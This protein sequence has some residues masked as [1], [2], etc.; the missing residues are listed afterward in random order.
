M[1]KRIACIALLLSCSVAANAE[2][3]NLCPCIPASKVWVV[4]SCE[5]WNCA[6]AA[7]ILAAG[8]P[9]VMAIPTSDL[10]YKWVVIRRVVAGSAI[11]SVPWD[12]GRD[13]RAPR[14]RNS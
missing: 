6:Q 14:T 11:I 12:S 2:D 4:T 5:T 3:G 10:K 13:A 9:Y 1:I 7:M 8:D